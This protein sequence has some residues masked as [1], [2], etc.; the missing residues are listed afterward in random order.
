MNQKT[1]FDYEVIVVDSGN[2]ETKSFIRK[3]K[4][5]FTGIIYKK[6]KFCR[7]RSLLR[8]I[9]VKISH[10]EILVFLDNDMLCCPGFLQRHYE[11]HKQKSNMVLMGLR[12]SLTNFDLCAFGEENLIENF[13]SLEK[14]SYYHDEREFFHTEI[15]PWRFVYSH[16]LSMRRETFISSKGF[17]KQFGNQ[18]GLEDLEFGFRLLES[19]YELCYLKGIYSYHQPH[20]TQSTNEQRKILP[21]QRLFVKLHNCFEV[22]LYVGLYLQFEDFGKD[23]LTIREKCNSPQKEELKTFDMIFGCIKSHNEGFLGERMQLGVLSWKKDKSVDK[24]LLLNTI[25]SLPREIQVC[26]I[27]EAFRISKKI[28]IQK[29]DNC[30][31]KIESLFK[32]IGYSIDVL[33]L[34]KYILIIPKNT[35]K[36]TLIETI[37]P[38]ISQ[39]EKRMVFLWFI[40]QLINDGKLLSIR[41][42]K[43]IKKIIDEDFSLSASDCNKIERLIN[44]GYNSPFYSHVYLASIFSNNNQLG[45]INSEDTILIDDLANIK[46]TSNLTATRAKIISPHDY[47]II[48]FMC[49]Y[50]MMIDRISRPGKKID[51][52]YFIEDLCN[53]E[54]IDSLL[55][56]LKRTKEEK[57]GMSAVIKMP[58]Y[59][60]QYKYSYPL[61]NENSKNEKLYLHNKF[62][63]LEYYR[64]IEKL[65]KLN[66]DNDVL[67]IK[68]N[69]S[70]MKIIDLI[71]SADTL[72]A[73]NSDSFVPPQVY[74]AVILGKRVLVNEYALVASEI[75]EHI[76]RVKSEIKKESEIDNGIINCRKV[77]RYKIVSSFSTVNLCNEECT[78]VMNDKKIKKITAKYEEIRKVFL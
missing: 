17:N 64:L 13:S 70:C 57:G 60:K 36:K 54:N 3:I 49:V 24:L 1:N 74:A 53:Y 58:E 16:S 42:T 66:L 55:S 29:D 5:N 19:G 37:L 62:T 10:G 51:F 15:E 32:L 35:E 65:R 38:D 12:K 26:I 73:V 77:N 50:S 22:E 34:E 47:S 31:P 48:S 18:W 9:G 44:V 78:A 76:T 4:K 21:N 39:P 2:D 27:S 25:Y 69:Y 14:L 61:H 46:G 56:Y 7:N 40:I 23:L 8:N 28:Y 11:A 71:E 33:K 72:I 30:I 6:V 75:E 41:D 63:E 59:H 67:I 68:D 45:F 52:L 43:N 20:L